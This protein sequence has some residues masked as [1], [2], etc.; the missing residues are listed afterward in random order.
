[1]IN[2]NPIVAW[3]P[4]QKLAV[5]QQCSSSGMLGNTN[6]TR[7]GVSCTLAPLVVVRRRLDGKRGSLKFTHEPWY[8]FDF[9]E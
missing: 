5:G 9:E 4:C 6:A 3:L 7:R 2:R 8:Y 1:M